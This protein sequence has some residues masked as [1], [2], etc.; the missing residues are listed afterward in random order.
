MCYVVCVIDFNVLRFLSSATIK[1]VILL[2]A[3]RIRNIIIKSGS[4]KV[5]FEVPRLYRHE[6]SPS[7]FIKYIICTSSFVDNATEIE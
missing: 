6:N 4:I 7:P 5:T 2:F 3:E 1:L